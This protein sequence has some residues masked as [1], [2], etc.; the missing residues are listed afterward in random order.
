MLGH[1]LNLEPIPV[2]RG[3]VYADWPMLGHVLNP[4]PIPVTRGKVY[5]DCPM[6][7]HAQLRPNPCD[8]V[9]HADQHILGHMLNPKQITGTKRKSCVALH[10]ASGGMSR[11]PLGAGQLAPPRK[12]RVDTGRQNQ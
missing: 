11:A 7:C 10:R 12:Q 4:E 9:D 8:Q 6:L 2:T 1:V 3:K 5:A